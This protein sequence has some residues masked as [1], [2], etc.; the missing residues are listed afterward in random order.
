M[1]STLIDYYKSMHS[2]RYHH[3]YSLSE[4]DDLMPWERD[5]MIA[6]VKSSLQ[7]EINNQG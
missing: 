3:G 7:E 2:L 4:L 6:M 5:I 1:S